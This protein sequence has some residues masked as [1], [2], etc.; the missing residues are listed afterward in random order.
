MFALA[1]AICFIL[2]FFN[3]DVFKEHSVVTLGLFALALHFV[4]TVTLPF[5][6]RQ[7]P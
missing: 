6:R 1:A 7:Q 2:G 5:G 4:W 3:A